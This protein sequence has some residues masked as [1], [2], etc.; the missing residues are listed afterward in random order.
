M[1]ANKSINTFFFLCFSFSCHLYAQQ[2]I[3]VTFLADINASGG[4]TSDKEGNIYIS[5]FGAQFGVT[6]SATHVYKWDKRSGEVSLFATGFIGASGA[7]FDRDGNFYQSNPVGNVISKRSP[8]GEIA[9]RWCDEGLK[10]PVGLEADDQGNIYVSNCAM[11]EIGK[12]SPDGSYETFAKSDLFKCP[13]G[14]TQ[15]PDGNLYACNFGSGHILKITP[16]GRV[17]TLVELKTL[18]GGPSPVGNGHVVYSNGWIYAT[19]IGLGE[20]FRIGLDGSYEKIVGIPGAFKN[21][22]GDVKTASFSKPNGIC[23]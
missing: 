7:C 19:T 15:D 8:D 5:D 1:I 12:V 10:T 11:Q 23:S 16:V 9:Y 14:L 4:V 21:V 13:N 3:K 20:V 18:Q 17:S 6:D 2:D 22:A